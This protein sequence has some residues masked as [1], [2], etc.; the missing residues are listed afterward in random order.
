MA[1]TRRLVLIIAIV[2][3]AAVA[4]TLPFYALSLDRSASSSSGTTLPSGCVKPP[5]GFLIVASDLG[6]NDS[7]L[8]YGKGSWPVLNV[9]EGS[10]VNI[11]VCN[12]A[13]YAHGFQISTYYQG[14]I[15]T[16]QPGEVLHVPAFV[17]NKAGNF[18]IYCSIPCPIH[19]YMQYGEL[20]VASP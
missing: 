18:L 14:S 2:I 20:R 1:S 11:T 7:E 12:T 6:Y 19:I 9:T 8:Y 15:V 10:T 5:G 16:V 3:V 4:V 13:N 17:A